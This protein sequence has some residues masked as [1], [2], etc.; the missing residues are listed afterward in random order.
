MTKL[1]VERLGPPLDSI[2]SPGSKHGIKVQNTRQ[3]SSTMEAMSLSHYMTAPPLLLTSFRNAASDVKR[4]GGMLPPIGAAQSLRLGTRFH[5]SESTGCADAEECSAGKLSKTGSSN[6]P[7][8]NGGAGKP[9]HPASSLGTGQSAPVDKHIEPSAISPSN[10]PANSF[11]RSTSSL[12][13]TFAIAQRRSPMKDVREWIRF[14][15]EEAKMQKSADTLVKLR[16]KNASP[17][18]LPLPF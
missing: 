17:Y 6:G 13:S 10:Q 11:E 4:G 16:G 14:F 12:A 7:A 8:A 2:S 9:A 5:T 1:V 15:Y 3:L 18:S